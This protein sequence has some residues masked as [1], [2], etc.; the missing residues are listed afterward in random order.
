MK[1]PHTPDELAIIEVLNQQVK[2]WNSGNM[3][4]FMQGYWASEEFR[5]VQKNGVIHG[6]Q[7]LYEAN[8]RT[9]PKAE[10]MGQLSFELLSIHPLA[11]ATFFVAARWASEDIDRKVAGIFSLVFQQ[12]DGRWVIVTEHTSLV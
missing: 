6:W 11:E 7:Q 8:K 10:Q 1:Q 4:A 3:E 9:F 5:F 2:D 12:K